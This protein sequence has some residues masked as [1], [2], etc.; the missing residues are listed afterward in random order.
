MAVPRPL[1]LA[2]VGVVLLGATFMATRNS[3]DKASSPSP[4]AAKAPGPSAAAVAKAATPALRPSKS[5]AQP[6]SQSAAKPKSQSSAAPTAKSAKPA[7][8]R[9]SSLRT[10]AAVARALAQRKVV[11]LAF[12]QPGADDRAT[13][14]AVQALSR[15]HLAAVFTERIGNISRY[16]PIVGSLGV[17]QAPAVVIV[18]QQRRARVVEGYIDAE[19]L[20]QEVAD[21]RG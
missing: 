5:A 20:A 2:L 10:P 17:T 16:R 9:G 7:T 6:K 15:K 12:F 18:N 19:T 8:R 3:S 4:P 14:S 13:R 21:A 11:V 1:L